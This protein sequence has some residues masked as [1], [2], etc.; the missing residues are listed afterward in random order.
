MTTVKTYH[1]EAEVI[2][3]YLI[4]KLP[5]EKEK[6]LYSEAIQ[7][8]NIQFNDAEKKIWNFMIAKTWSIGYIDAALA[9][10]NPEGNIRKRIFTMLAILETSARNCD[11]FLP[12]K[13]FVIDFL[14]FLLTGVRAGFRLIIGII[15]LR[16]I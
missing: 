1:Q 5:I 15:F 12:K 2:T 16:L 11:L 8:L 3:L 13:F 7:K 10:K 6:Q 14:K 4:H 9:V